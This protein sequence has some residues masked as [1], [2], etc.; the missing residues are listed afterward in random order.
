MSTST[1]DLKK[2][3]QTYLRSQGFYSGQIDGVWGELSKK[4]FGRYMSHLQSLGMDIGDE[5]SIAEDGTPMALSGVVVLDPGH[6]GSQ[7]IGGSSPNNATSASG[8]LEKAMTLDF[9]KRVQK[10][11]KQIANLAPGSD[12]KVHLT[13]SGDTN[14]GLSDRAQ[15][16]EAK[17]ADI[18]VSIHFNGFNGSV[19]GT[20]TLIL[21]KAN[22]NV[23][24]AEDRKLAER[25]Q[26]SMFIAIKKL[27]PAARNR[28]IKDG[29]KLGVLN[30]IS[31][32]NVRGNRNTRAC[33]VEVEFIDNPDVDKLLNT[34]A[35]S[36]MA[37][38][39]I[40]TAI[41]EAIVDDLA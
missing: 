20:E 10:Q 6:G 12:I 9:A 18:F 14:L 31:L 4:A 23:N 37:R 40:A 15:V 13:R 25:I 35:G 39:S 22:G 8:V 30:D 26:E 32:G 1:K 17:N 29:Q 38:D 21:S 19:R 33:L 34:I 5:Q 27:D 16:A 11:L 41:A 7:R 2:L 36:G 3:A 28:G 24:E